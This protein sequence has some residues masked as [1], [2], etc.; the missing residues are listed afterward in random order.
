M[1][2]ML[3]GYRGRTTPTFIRQFNRTRRRHPPLDTNHGPSPTPTAR[4]QATSPP[5]T[6][7][8]AIFHV[9]EQIQRF[10]MTTVRQMWHFR[11]PLT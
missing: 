7:H 10:E 6:T 5:T 3:L 9:A 1:I 11:T 8:R 4:L 2:P